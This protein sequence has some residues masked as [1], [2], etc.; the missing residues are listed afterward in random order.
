MTPFSRTQIWSAL[1]TVESRCATTTV[2][3]RLAVINRSRASCT[4]RSL[5]ASKALVASSKSN[6][7]GFRTSAR[8]MAMRCFCPPLSC[9]FRVLPKSVL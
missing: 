3:R 1:Q 5:V 2:V 7:D 9:A 4:T 6:T 8:A